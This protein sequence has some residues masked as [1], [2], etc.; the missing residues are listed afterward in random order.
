MQTSKQ[1]G[2]STCLRDHPLVSM[3][4]PFARRSKGQRSAGDNIS[5]HMCS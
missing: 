5:C 3:T 1:D 2:E 4:K